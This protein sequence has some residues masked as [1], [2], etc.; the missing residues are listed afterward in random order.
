[1]QYRVLHKVFSAWFRETPE[2]SSKYEAFTHQMQEQSVSLLDI[3]TLNIANTYCHECIWFP[4]WT[5][6][7]FVCLSVTITLS[8]CFNLMNEPFNRGETWSCKNFAPCWESELTYCIPVW[9]M[10]VGT[11]HTFVRAWWRIAVQVVTDW[12]FEMRCWGW[13]YSGLPSLLLSCK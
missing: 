7:R 5:Q 3:C 8:P 13:I 10:P 6:N 1:M 11:Q 9:V 4:S 2:S 12:M